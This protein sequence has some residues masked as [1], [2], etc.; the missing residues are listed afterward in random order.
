MEVELEA[1]VDDVV[2]VPVADVV[3]VLPKLNVFGEVGAVLN[4]KLNPVD[5]AEVEEVCRAV[6]ELL[7]NEK[8]PVLLVFAWVVWV[9]EAPNS[10]VV[11]DDAPN[12]VVVEPPNAVEAVED[13]PN[14]E[15]VVPKAVFVEP[16]SGVETDVVEAKAGLLDEELAPNTGVAAE[17]VAPKAG[18][19]APKAGTG[20]DVV[21]SNTGGL[22]EV[23]P[24]AG[25]LLAEVAPNFEDAEPKV[26]PDVVTPNAGGALLEEPK[27]ARLELVVGVPKTKLASVVPGLVTAEVLSAVALN[28]KIPVGLDVGTDDELVFK[29]AASLGLKVNIPVDGMLEVAGVEGWGRETGGVDLPNVNIP[30]AGVEAAVAA[31]VAVVKV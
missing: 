25:V 20:A 8:E 24:N 31:P 12:A 11:V 6:L 3:E 16:K 13:T 4:V 5:G 18:V 10:G 14:G 22:V 15:E 30:V 28:E 27:A 9:L 7:S 1:A 2:V 17:E 23:A 29:L 21:A 26:L 19:L